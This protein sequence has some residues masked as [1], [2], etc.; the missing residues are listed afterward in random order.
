MSEKMRLAH[1]MFAM[2]YYL[3]LISQNAWDDAYEASCLV[4]WA[5]HE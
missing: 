3:E 5:A 1:H 2:M 4:T